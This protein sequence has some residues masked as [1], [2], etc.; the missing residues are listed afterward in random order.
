MK[1]LEEAP[2]LATLRRLFGHLLPSD[3]VNPEGQIRP[4]HWLKIYKRERT[5]VWVLRPTRWNLAKELRPPE[6]I[7]ESV[8][9]RPLLQ[10]LDQR[11]DLMQ[12]VFARALCGDE[13][14]IALMIS[15]ARGAVRAL[16]HLEKRQAAKLKAKA[17]TCSDWPVLLSP[18]PQDISHAKECVARLNVGAKAT[19]PRHHR[20]RLD[21]RNFWTQLAAAGVEECEENKVTVP[22]LEAQASGGRRQ[23]KALKIWRTRVEGT[24]HYPNYGDCVLIADWEKR[25]VTL[26]VPI[27]ESNFKQ[28][29][30]VVQ[31][32]LLEYWWLNRKAYHTA[33]AQISDMTAPKESKKRNLALA[34][35]RRALRSLV[36]L[37]Q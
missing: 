35:V 37:R 16:G 23:R 11:E 20:Q 6:Q 25:C 5:E 36:G 26:S 14:A 30:S 4:G 3:S 12:Q 15:T 8:D 9:K 17:E 10:L 1:V 34:Q 31:L 19:I 22:V 21:P 24:I 13:Q 27:I 7:A 33:L 18:N 29:W 2:D 32:W 28:W